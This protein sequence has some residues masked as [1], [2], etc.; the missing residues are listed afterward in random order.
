MCSSWT[1]LLTPVTARAANRVW[2]GQ[3]FEQM[4]QRTRFALLVTVGWTLRKWLFLK[5]MYVLSWEFCTSATP[6]RPCDTAGTNQELFSCQGH[7][8][9]GDLERWDSKAGFQKLQGLIRAHA[10]RNSWDSSTGEAAS[11]CISTMMCALV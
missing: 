4:Q 10:L 6:Y 11:T 8:G 3:T 7:G 9:S 2:M 1:R 5:N